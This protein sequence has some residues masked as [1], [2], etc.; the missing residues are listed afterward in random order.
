[1]KKIIACMLSMMLFLGSYTSVSA[2]QLPQFEKAAL[3]LDTR[4]STNIDQTQFITLHPD[5]AYLDGISAYYVSA[6]TTSIIIT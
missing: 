2:A 3:L 4:T 5:D 1:M 6:L